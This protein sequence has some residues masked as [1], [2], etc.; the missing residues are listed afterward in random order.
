MI[1]FLPYNF[2]S[3][4]YLGFWVLNTNCDTNESLLLSTVECSIKLTWFK[5]V[6][7]F[8]VMQYLQWCHIIIANLIL[9]T[10][11][12]YTIRMINSYLKIASKGKWFI[13]KC[14]S[15]WV[16]QTLLFIWGGRNQII[17]YLDSLHSCSQASSHF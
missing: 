3:I 1:T 14:I 7:F 5:I 11:T 4:N 6:I 8:L 16:L 9:F 12:V 13:T 15:I 17:L 10:C 2:D